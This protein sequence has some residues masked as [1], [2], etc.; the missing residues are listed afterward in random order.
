MRPGGPGV[1]GHQTGHGEEDEAP[2]LDWFDAPG[3]LDDR[4][5]RSGY[6]ARVADDQLEPRRCDSEPVASGGFPAAEQGGSDVVAGVPD[7]T[8][9]AEGGGF[10]EEHNRQTRSGE[11]AL[12][13]GVE[14][15]SLAGQAESLLGATG[16]DH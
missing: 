15:S 12:E 11:V 14:T 5:D 1:A 3:L 7:S 8:E 16:H 4:F 2:P 13:G 10:P 6:C 9:L